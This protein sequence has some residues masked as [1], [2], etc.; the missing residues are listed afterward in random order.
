MTPALLPTMMRALF[1]IEKI[2]MGVD[3]GLDEV[4]FPHPVPVGSRVRGGAKLTGVRE[5]PVGRLAA[6]RMTVEVEGQPRPPVWP[7]R[8]RCSSAP[9]GRGLKRG[10]FTTD[11]ATPSPPQ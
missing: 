3:F 7:T 2:E 11:F 1:D 4:R 6:V 5:T 8:C 9:D 10:V